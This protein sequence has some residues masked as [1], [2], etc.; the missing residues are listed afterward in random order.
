MKRAIDIAFPLAADLA[1]A[2][3]VWGTARSGGPGATA[4]RPAAA[5][6]CS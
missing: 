2:T 3:G 5:A 6:R 4:R 1:T